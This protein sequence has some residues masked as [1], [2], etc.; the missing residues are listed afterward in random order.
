MSAE[1]IDDQEIISQLPPSLRTLMTLE[2]FHL[3]KAEQFQDTSRDPR[4]DTRYL[5]QN[6]GALRLPC[7]WVHRKHLGLHG[8]QA[9]VVDQLAFFD[10]DGSH[11]RVLFPVHPSSAEDYKEFLSHVGARDAL[12]EGLCIWAA[13]TSSTRT[14][15]AWPDRAPHKALFVKTSLHSAIFGDRR[16][17]LMKVGRSVGLSRLVQDCRADLPP[18]LSCLPEEFGFA[19]RRPPHSGAIIRSIPAEIRD[20]RV[21]AAPMF[22]LLGGSGT[23][24]PLLL[25]LLERCGMQPLRFVEEVLCAPFARLWLDMSLR[26]GLIL[27][28]HGQDLMLALAPNLTPLGRFYYRD[29]EGL[30]VDWELRRR[31]GWPAPHGMPHDWS[32]RETYASWGYPYSDLLWYK[33]RISLFDYLHFVLNETELSL[34]EWRDRGLIGGQK[35]AE[36]EVTMIFS[37]HLF[38]AVEEMFGVRVDAPFNVYRSLNRFLIF[39]LKVRREVMAGRREQKAGE[40]TKVNHT[41]KRGSRVRP[42]TLGAGRWHCSSVAR[43]RIR[44]QAPPLTATLRLTCPRRGSFGTDPCRRPCSRTGRRARELLRESLRTSRR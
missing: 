10:G 24:V 26:R 14:L 7:F 40:V 37:R 32:W 36:N 29:F 11:G 18:A 34:I 43:G 42:S 5:P 15:L 6:C 2:R 28:A 17:C 20:G 12:Q 30:Q 39:L 21:L 19:A 33:W 27:E 31:C 8:C 3:H 44:I 4:F 13:P 35:C 23:H 38:K 1:R 41:R 22:S 25:T 9:D 16:V